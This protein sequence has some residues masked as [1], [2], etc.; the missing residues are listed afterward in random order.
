MLIGPS[1]LLL[2]SLEGIRKASLL[3][4]GFAGLCRASSWPGANNSYVRN[5][6]RG[7]SGCFQG[8]TLSGRWPRGRENLISRVDSDQNSDWTWNLPVVGVCRNGN[9]RQSWKLDIMWLMRKIWSAKMFN[10][11]G[12]VGVFVE[13]WP[14][15]SFCRPAFRKVDLGTSWM[16][17]IFKLMFCRVQITDCIISNGIVKTSQGKGRIVVSEAAD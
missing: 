2:T 5:A 4:W 6:W 14:F 16:G 9:K 3:A 7:L 10:L 17:Q 12:F 15:F 1:S 13:C 11:F 8:S